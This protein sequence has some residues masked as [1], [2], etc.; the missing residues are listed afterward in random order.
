MF[1]NNQYGKKP[2]ISGIGRSLTGMVRAKLPEPKF[3]CGLKQDSS[4]KHGLKRCQWEVASN[5]QRLV[6][7]HL[8][9][10]SAMSREKKRNGHLTQFIR[11]LV[12]SMGSPTGREPYGD[13]VPIVVSDRE[14]LSQGE[15]EQGRLGWKALKV[16]GMQMANNGGNRFV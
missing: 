9:G 14:S 3:L 16:C 15:G 11:H 12:G 4:L 6:D 8:T 1:G 2:C 5:L 7:P 13:G 10:Q